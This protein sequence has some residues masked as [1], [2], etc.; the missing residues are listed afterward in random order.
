MHEIQLK[1]IE[2]NMT[3]KTAEKSC[4]VWQMEEF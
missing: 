4:L 3:N 1:T 2:D